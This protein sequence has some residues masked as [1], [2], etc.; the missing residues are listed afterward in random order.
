MLAPCS[1]WLNT[2][3]VSCLDTTEIIFQKE[4][5]SSI[6]VTH[7]L[8]KRTGLVFDNHKTK[9]NLILFINAHNIIKSMDPILADQ[10]KLT[11]NDLFSMCLQSA[12]RPESLD[13]FFSSFMDVWGFIYSK[14]IYVKKCPYFWQF[15]YGYFLLLFLYVRHNHT[16]KDTFW[17]NSSFNEIVI[18]IKSLNFFFFLNL[19]FHFFKSIKVFALSEF[20]KTVKVYAHFVRSNSQNNL[21]APIF[22]KISYFGIF[23]FLRSKWFKKK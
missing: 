13:D 17:S 12:G 2:P 14:F 1:M 19:V 5:I 15:T 16:D 9:S 7:F 23:S 10:L 11:N 18:L 3:D 21:W 6:D 22:K 4:S 8:Y 20:L